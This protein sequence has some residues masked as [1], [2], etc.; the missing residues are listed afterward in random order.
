MS[1]E[2]GQGGHI[3]RLENSFKN[4]KFEQD[5]LLVM[6][7]NELV[8]ELAVKGN[9]QQVYNSYQPKPCKCGRQQPHNQSFPFI[10]RKDE[11]RNFLFKTGLCKPPTPPRQDWEGGS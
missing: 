6:Y 4:A 11:S 8:T 9:S 10:S 5:D 2:L 3:K 7:D 1:I